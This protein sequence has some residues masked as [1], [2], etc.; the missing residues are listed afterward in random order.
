MTNMRSNVH[1]PK[2]L[3]KKVLSLSDHDCFM[4]VRKINYQKMSFR[5]ITLR[6]YFK[7]NHTVLGRDIENYDW[8]PVYTET[9]VNTALSYMEQG[10]TSII[11]RHAPKITKRVKGRKFPWLT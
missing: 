8:N 3:L 11:D 9:N 7:Y 1:H 2:V 4:C 6:D 5:T 10:L